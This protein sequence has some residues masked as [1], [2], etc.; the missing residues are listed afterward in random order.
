[1][2]DQVVEVLLIPLAVK[3]DIATLAASR[4]KKGGTGIIPQS[5]DRSQLDGGQDERLGLP[6]EV[7]RNGQE[8]RSRFSESFLHTGAGADGS[9]RPQRL[10]LYSI[11]VLIANAVAL[12]VAFAVALVTTVLVAPL[13]LA[14]RPFDSRPICLLLPD[15][16]EYC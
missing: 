7:A 14:E 15:T 13:A 4:Q 10:T 3:N 8:V 12:A 2:S 9:A 11:F 1:M 16:T 6:E 5:G